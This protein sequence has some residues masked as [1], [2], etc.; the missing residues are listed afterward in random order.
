MPVP[1][2][3][4]EKMVPSGKV[5]YNSGYPSHNGSMPFYGTNQLFSENSSEPFQFKF[6]SG[7]TSLVQG[8]PSQQT[9][10][11]FPFRNPLNGIDDSAK[12]KA[13]RTSQVTAQQQHLSSSN[14]NGHRDTHD[15][16]P[17]MG[18]VIQQ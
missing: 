5:G 12:P 17:M 4:A 10:G 16:S 3:A 11:N 18:V 7:H 1:R 6:G 14:Q 13:E 15:D 9:Q 2:T 8:G